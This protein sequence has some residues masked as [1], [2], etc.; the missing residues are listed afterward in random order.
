MPAPILRNTE[1]SNNK[2]EGSNNQKLIMF[3]L[4]NVISGAPIIRG[5]NQLPNPPINEG[6]TKKN[7]DK[8]MICNKN[9][10]EVVVVV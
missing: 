10:I 9:I 6:L 7:H 1:P 2:S 3:I 5:T 8:C 4:G